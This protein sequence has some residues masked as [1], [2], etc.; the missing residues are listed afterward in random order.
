[1]TGDVSAPLCLTLAP[2]GD[3]YNALPCNK[4]RIFKEQTNFQTCLAAVLSFDPFVTHAQVLTPLPLLPPALVDTRKHTDLAPLTAIT[5]VTMVCWYHFHPHLT[6]HLEAITHDFSDNFFETLFRPD[7][8]Y[9]KSSDPF[10]S[11][12]FISLWFAFLTGFTGWIT[13]EF[14]WVD[15][16]WSLTPP[17]YAWLFALHPFLALGE[18]WPSSIGGYFFGRPFLLAWLTTLWGVRL[19]YNFWR[20][21]GYAGGGEDY[22]WA[23][24]RTWFSHFTLQMFN[25]FFIAIFQVRLSFFHSLFPASFV[26]FVFLL[27]FVLDRFPLPYSPLLHVP[28]P[29]LPFP[30][31]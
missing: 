28:P 10:V 13:Q 30:F 11:L 5:L 4:W 31:L 21:G 26:L 27:Y 12:L 3:D 2:C 6:W 7:L 22:R 19:T 18:A 1:M 29:S 14:S 16:I 17:F 9:L 20:K 15:R 24:V 25:I 23:E 8:V